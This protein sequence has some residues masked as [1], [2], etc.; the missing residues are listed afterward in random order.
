MVSNELIWLVFCC[1]VFD[2]APHARDSKELFAPAT[3]SS[4]CSSWT[5]NPLVPGP[6]GAGLGEELL[7]R[8]GV[9]A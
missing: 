7:D 4:G 9:R 2:S 1:I 8:V 5:A 6:G 3:G